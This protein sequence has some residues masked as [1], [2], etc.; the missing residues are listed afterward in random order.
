[1]V[2]KG[3]KSDS[4]LIQ[5]YFYDEL[6]KGIVVAVAV[7][8]TIFYREVVLHSEKYPNI[9]VNNI[10]FDFTRDSIFMIDTKGQSL[11]SF[12][13]NG[14]L[15]GVG[16]VHDFIKNLNIRLFV[17]G[18]ELA[19]HF[20]SSAIYL[21]GYES[22]QLQTEED[23][24]EYF[25]KPRLML[26]KN[27]EIKL[28]GESPFHHKN[29]HYYFDG[30]LFSTFLKHSE[31]LLVSF[32]QSDTVFVYTNGELTSR[33]H[34]PSKFRTEQTQYD[35]SKS[36]DNSYNWKYQNSIGRYLFL[37]GT[38]ESEFIFR[39]YRSEQQTN[40]IIAFNLFDSTLIDEL[41]I[42]SERFDP[43]LIIPVKDGFYISENSHSK[44]EVL[45]RK[46]V[47]K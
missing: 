35:L 19:Q 7:K 10:Y 40:T 34:I 12:D 22:E 37:Y 23:V 1:M 39:I 18:F 27:N 41:L 30:L 33:L 28:F 13:Y 26:L 38:S 14:Q 16:K 17:N 9:P 44:K 5:L 21:T 46:F 4:E 8:D 3:I 25:D 2:I 6:T 15:V 43:R 24:S 42:S 47:V 11:W 29:G 45:L 36:T 31:Q 20:G 32:E